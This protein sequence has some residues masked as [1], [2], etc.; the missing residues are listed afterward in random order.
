LQ[1]QLEHPE[2]GNAVIAERAIAN[3][4]RLIVT[5]TWWQPVPVLIGSATSPIDTAVPPHVPEA[6]RDF[7]ER[8]TDIPI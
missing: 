4:V 8:I 7:L 6:A 3:Q 1:P 2:A 5:R